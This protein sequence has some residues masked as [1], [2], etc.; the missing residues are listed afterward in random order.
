MRLVLLPTIYSCQGLEGKEHYCSSRRARVCQEQMQRGPII[1]PT[2]KSRLLLETSLSTRV[3]NSQYR[4]RLAYLHTYRV[5][6]VLLLY[7]STEA[8]K[9]IYPACNVRLIYRRTPNRIIRKNTN[10]RLS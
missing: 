7:S 6:F 3:L 8:L 10:T 9:T 4:D 1:P 5:R 2:H